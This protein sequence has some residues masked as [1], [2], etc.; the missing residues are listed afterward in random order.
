MFD[1][2]AVAKIELV[3]LFLYFLLKKV[4]SQNFD[5]FYLYLQM[6]F[7]VGTLHNCAGEF[8]ERR[9]RIQG[10]SSLAPSSLIV[11][12]SLRTRAFEAGQKYF[13]KK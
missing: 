5:K 10:L 2:L 4:I 11:G 12:S 7:W 1:N 6:Y 13:G 8:P 9:E 3:K